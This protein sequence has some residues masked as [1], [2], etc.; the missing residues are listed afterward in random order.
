MWIKRCM[1]LLWFIKTRNV[2]VA[3]KQ[4]NVSVSVIFQTYLFSDFTFFTIFYIAPTRRRR[5]KAD[6]D[7]HPYFL[8]ITASWFYDEGE[9]IFCAVWPFTFFWISP[10][11]LGTF[12]KLKKIARYLFHLLRYTQNSSVK[13]R[14]RRRKNMEHEKTRERKN[15]FEQKFLLK[16]AP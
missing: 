8:N 2:S 4:S 6:L 15:I 13:R 5:K 12:Q 14:R 9:N 1:P 11:F 10:N 3:M 7:K 16:L